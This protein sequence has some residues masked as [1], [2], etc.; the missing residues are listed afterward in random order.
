MAAAD[1][2]VI[3]DTSINNDGLIKGF[4]A[5]K[6][7]MDSIADKAEKTNREIQ[8]ALSGASS[9]KAGADVQ[10]LGKSLDTVTDSAKEAEN[11]L[12]DMIQKAAETKAREG[13]VLTGPIQGPEA[14]TG[15]QQYDT[16]EIEKFVADYAANM[17]TAEQHTSELL[18]ALQAAQQKVSDLKAQ[19]FF[20]DDEEYQQ[21]ERELARI[22]EDIKGIKQD[23]IG[24]ETVANPF[25]LDTL[26][27]K[28][29]EAELEMQRLVAAGKGLGDADYDRAYTKL[30]Q[31]KSEARAYAQELASGGTK[32]RPIS[33]ALSSMVSKGKQL[34][35]TLGKAVGSG[36][37]KMGSALKSAAS[38][39]GKLIT[40]GKS[41]K[42]SFGGALSAVKRLAPALLAARG[43]MG[44][45]RKAVS[46][47]MEQNQALSQQLSNAWTGLGNLLG[48][49]IEKMV[50]LVSSAVAYFTKFL[51]LLGITGKTASSQISSAGSAAG[52]E[53]KKLQRQLASFDELN[54]LNSK[55]EDS[56]GGG[57]GVGAAG[58]EMADV[59]LPDFVK[60][61]VDQIKAGKWGEAAATLTSA[62]NDMVAKVDW[63]GI[64]AKIG[65][66]LDGGLTFLATALKTFDWY[67]LGADLGT[68]INSIITNVDWANLGTILGAKFTIL[69]QG[70][71]GL[72]AT[73]D[74]A[75]LGQA[76]ADGFRGLWDSIDWGQASQ[77]VSDGVIG[78][79]TTISTAIKATDWQKLGNDVAGFIAGIDWNGVT[80]SL[81]DGVGAA[82]GGLTAFLWGL[83]K[84][85]WASVVAWWKENAYEDGKFTMQGLLNGI[86]EGI[87]NIGSW[88]KQHIFDPFIKGFKDAFGIHSPSTVMREQGGYIIAGLLNGITTAWASVKQWISDAV[89]SIKRV[90]TNAWNSLKTTTA[91]IWKGIANA[92][93][94]PI[95]GIIG[96]INGMI[97]GIVSGVNAVIG[98]LNSLHFSIPKWVPALGGKTFGFDI[99]YLSA[100]RIPMLAKGAVLPPN[101]PFLAMVGDQKHGTNIEAPLETIQEAVALVMDDMIASNTAGQEAMLSVLR[102]ILSAV[103]GIQIGDDVLAQAVE[104][105]QRKMAIL[106]GGRA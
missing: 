36:F 75:A 41:I 88:I 38:G 63:A 11:A 87:K 80:D 94:G 48:P 79:L 32:A 54:I 20:W 84:D 45:L 47:Y 92:V 98:V 4:K 40:G 23:T 83:I 77:T 58:Y 13:S 73:I 26:A 9:G 49:I 7:G 66:G 44:I 8:A 27:G 15:Y 104:R 106:R 5:I 35:E 64:G 25:G 39:I 50:N 24:G 97:S 72:F 81:F 43:V 74:W 16:A 100:P 34:A 103:L 12:D 31:L 105:S 68:S 30:A 14:M 19:G 78:T 22:K 18:A 62:L 46:A 6:S 90:F 82:L 53:T 60:L 86:W 1:G 17:K 33:D 69:I 99:G 55:E 76:L 96:F 56:S 89:E 42:Q 101:Q 65:K 85:A 95:N 67:A 37:Q 102:E 21:A 93:K 61:M 3:I 59:K 71:G 57:G 70:L 51:S 10:E 2:S 29:R 91:T 28:V 52:K